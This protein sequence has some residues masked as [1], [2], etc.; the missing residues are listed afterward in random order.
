MKKAAL[1]LLLLACCYRSFSQEKY[2]AVNYYKATGRGWGDGAYGRVEINN[3]QHEVSLPFK[4]K[5]PEQLYN[6]LLSYMKNRPG[7][8]IT[9]NKGVK[10]GFFQYRDFSF[11]GTKDKCF[12]D[13]VALTYIGVVF[14]KPDSILITLG[15]TSKIFASIFDARLQITPDD[16]VASVNDAPFNEYQCMQPA[17]ERVMVTST[18]T[19]KRELKQA[20]P[21]SVFDPDGKIVNA[22]NKELIEKYFDNYITDLKTYL[23]DYF[24]PKK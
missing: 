9:Y 14:D 7:L 12:A 5:T 10:S 20:Y 1:L 24:K 19:Q 2:F 22:Y 13:L 17:D 18:R 23:E 21:D 15:V 3:P 4:G 16:D 6:G 8:K 11:I